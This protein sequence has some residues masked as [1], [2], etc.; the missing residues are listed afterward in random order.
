MFRAIL[1]LRPE[2]QNC[3]KP[4]WKKIAYASLQ[5][6][7]VEV[8]CCILV[9]MHHTPLPLAVT[10]KP[11][12]FSSMEP[13]PST[14]PRPATFSSSHFLCTEK[15]KQGKEKAEPSPS[16]STSAGTLT[17]HLRRNH[18]VDAS[19]LLGMLPFL[20]GPVLGPESCLAVAGTQK[21][22]IRKS[23][24]GRLA[25]KS[26]SRIFSTM[27][28]HS[29]SLSSYTMYEQVVV[30]SVQTCMSNSFAFRGNVGSARACC[31]RKQGLLRPP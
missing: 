22:S 5:V 18:A 20:F 7:V 11:E 23:K 15:T 29:M 21:V 13:P 4:V 10:M 9:L 31:A 28:F 25:R 3:A 27:F 30:G 24:G 1:G 16:S 17:L 19:T 26:P 8:F 12:I 14:P 6:S 2:A